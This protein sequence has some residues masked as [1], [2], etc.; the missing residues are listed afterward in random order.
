MAKD[1]IAAYKRGTVYLL[2]PQKH[3]GTYVLKLGDSKHID[4]TRE[5]QYGKNTDIIFH[6]QCDYYWLVE[7]A[8][9][10]EFNRH[11]ECV[12]IEKN[13]KM[14]PTKEY[15]RGNLQDMQDCWISVVS[16]IMRRHRSLDKQ[17]NVYASR[18]SGPVVVDLVVDS[19]GDDDTSMGPEYAMNN[20]D[21]RLNLQQTM[22][23]QF[24]SSSDGDTPDDT[25]ETPLSDSPSD[26]NTPMVLRETTLSGQK[27]PLQ[28]SSAFSRESSADN[29]RRRRKTIPT[30][31]TT[32][33]NEVFEEW[34]STW[35][36][37]KGS[38]IKTHDLRNNHPNSYN[39]YCEKTGT[40]P[41][42]RMQFMAAMAALGHTPECL[43]IPRPQGNGV[44]FVD[45]AYIDEDCPRPRRNCRN[46]EDFSRNGQNLSKRLSKERIDV[47]PANAHFSTWEN[48]HCLVYDNT[49][50]EWG[51]KRP[52]KTRPICHEKCAKVW[53]SYE[54]F[55]ANLDNKHRFNKSTFQNVMEE[56]GFYRVRSEQGV[57]CGYEG[58]D[59]YYTNL[60]VTGEPL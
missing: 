57:P 12:K 13:G 49:T 1:M 27:R 56:R 26:S 55:S 9:K 10:D 59:W 32:D 52:R 45:I 21:S 34:C 28:T 22:R 20:V 60:K 30:P 17:I 4:L 36:I 16:K 3:I 29:K 33:E 19:S 40:V 47:E 39:N 38:K 6:V 5:K 58:N 53:V 8:L 50:E 23:Q 43:Y 35:H 48:E 31:L 41:M 11:F 15:F 18:E 24:N 42:K 7:K 54:K 51:C 37:V 46:S 2:Q 25:S 14:L 44:G